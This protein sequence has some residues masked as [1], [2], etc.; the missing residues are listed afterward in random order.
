M[1]VSLRPAQEADLPLYYRWQDEEPHWDR[2]SCG[3]VQLVHPY[4]VFRARY[5]EALSGGGEIAFSVLADARVVGRMV[6]YDENPRNRSMEIGY[7]LS[8]DA[9]GQGIGREAL[10]LF[11]GI[12]FT[13]PGKRLHKLYATTWAENLASIALLEHA[14]FRLDGRLRDHYMIDGR[15]SDELCYSLLRSEWQGA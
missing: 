8:E 14:G 5:V 6:A 7:Y 10:A 3:P 2:Y 9:R 12:L 11:V 13:W 4:P 1:D 15:Y